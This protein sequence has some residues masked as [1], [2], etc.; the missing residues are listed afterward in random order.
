MQRAY[1]QIIHDMALQKLPA[2]FCMD[3]A[4]LVGND[5]PTHHGIFDV[6]FMRSIP[7]MIV[8][9]PMDGNEMYSLIYTAVKKNL[10]LSIRYPKMT[11]ILDSQFKPELLELGSWKLLNDGESICILTFGSMIND[12]LKV[13][14]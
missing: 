7:N 4:G 13:V 9:A 11:T 12:C 14:K 6:S 8:T 5:G 3:R 10:L 1:D 2:I